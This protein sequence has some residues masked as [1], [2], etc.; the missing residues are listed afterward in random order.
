MMLLFQ[1]KYGQ[2]ILVQYKFANTILHRIENVW[3]EV[4]EKNRYYII[5]GIYRHPNQQIDE[6]LGIPDCV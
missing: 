6:F 4:D 3:L 5:G 1:V 2:K